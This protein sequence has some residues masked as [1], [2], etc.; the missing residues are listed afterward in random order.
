LG[1]GT[2]ASQSPITCPKRQLP[3]TLC[4]IG[5]NIIEKITI[6]EISGTEE[7]YETDFKNIQIRCMELIKKYPENKD[8]FLSYIE[9]QKR[10]YEILTPDST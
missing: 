7:K 9:R 2:F 3:V 10:E 6:N 8:L 4:E 5:A 1:Q